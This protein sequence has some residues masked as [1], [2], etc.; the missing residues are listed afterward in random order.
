[1]SNALPEGTPLRGGDYIVESVLGVGGFGITYR[2]SEPLLQRHV[3]I[4]EFFPGGCRRD[5]LHLIPNGEWTP[6]LVAH[7]RHKFV[8][9]GRTLARLRHASI[10][11]IYSTFEQHDSA[12]LVMEFI[13]GQTLRDYMASRKGRVQVDEAISFIQQA[14]EALDVVHVRGLLHRDLKPA[15][16]MLR[17]DGQLVLID[18]GSAREISHAPQR[19]TALLTPGYA[20][21][22]QYDEYGIFG[23]TIDIYALAAVLYHLLTGRVPVNAISRR[24][25][26][27]LPHPR[28]LRPDIPAVVSDAV[29]KGLEMDPPLRPASAREFLALLAPPGERIEVLAEWH[30]KPDPTVA[31]PVVRS[32]NQ[33]TKPIPPD[34]STQPPSERPQNPRCV[35][36]LKGHQRAIYSVAWSPDGR[37]LLSAG[38]DT[39][40]RLWNAETGELQQVLEGHAAVVNSAAW[41]QDGTRLCSGSWYVGVLVWDP[42]SGGIERTL[43]GHTKSVVAVAWGPHSRWIASA[44]ADRT[45]RVWDAA[46][47]DCIATLQGHTDRVTALAWRPDGQTLATGGDDRT[48]RLWAAERGEETCVLRGA[49]NAVTSVAWSPNGRRL[50]ASGYA[51]GAVWIWDV[52]SERLERTLEVDPSAILLASYSVAWRP[53]GSVLAFGCQD[54]SVQIW[55]PDAGAPVHILRDHNQAVHS[56]AWSPDGRYLATA[57]EDQ[58]LRIWEVP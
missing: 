53:D 57:S 52:E 13:E 3:A 21:L 5:L 14:C 24:N 39:T 45:A 42:A 12:Y 23:P 37:R 40:V 38:R 49:M 1:M 35:R 29:M 25:G 34:D 19:H 27:A 11:P 16:L 18:F 30:S 33:L 17:P 56:V 41:N 8:R 9:E 43:S 6:D 58:T 55:D 31:V 46:S 20:P 32:P 2:A 44:S 26:M 54:G 36:T 10:V 28:E 48:V 4:K 47:G 50:A 22:E 15:N 51:A 7:Y